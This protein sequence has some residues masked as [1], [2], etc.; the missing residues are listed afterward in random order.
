[1]IREYRADDTDALV[2]IWER[3][4]ALAHPFLP[5]SFV[6]RLA[7]EIRDSHLQNAETWVLD[8]DGRPG[9]FIALIGDE[10]GGLFL[11]PALIGRGHGKALVDHAVA[12]KG[13][14][15]VEVFREN[16]VAR[17]FYERYGFAL[18]EEYLHEPSGA[19]M[20]RMAMP[21]A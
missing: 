19:V 18:E 11:D 9:G 17:P 10:I 12:L 4:N 15:R 1:M 20:C 16:D 5:A 6:A 21:S 13:P 14:L 3:A 8:L 2:A 7:E